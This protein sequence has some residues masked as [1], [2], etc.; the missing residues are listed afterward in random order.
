MGMN[1]ISWEWSTD[2]KTKMRNRILSVPKDAKRKKLF[3]AMLQ[4]TLDRAVGKRKR[5]RPKKEI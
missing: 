2:K 5:G 3:I 1:L 4:E